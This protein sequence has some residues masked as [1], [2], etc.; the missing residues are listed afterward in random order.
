M[1]EEDAFSV[2]VSLMSQYKLRELYKPTMADLSLCFYQLETVVEVFYPYIHIFTFSSLFR[3]CSLCCTYI[4]K[5]WY[6]Y[7]KSNFKKFLVLISSGFPHFNVLE[8]LV[9]Y[10]VCFFSSSQCRLSSHG[11]IPC[12]RNRCYI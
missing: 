3:K 6:V 4:L 12:R 7:T 9:S 11:Y 10:N 1:P 5:H 2:F 8:L